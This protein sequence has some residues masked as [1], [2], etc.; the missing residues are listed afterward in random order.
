MFVICLHSRRH[1]KFCFLLVHNDLQN[2]NIIEINIV[3]SRIETKQFQSVQ[4][5]FIT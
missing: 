1:P 4:T 2:R 5:I 3:L